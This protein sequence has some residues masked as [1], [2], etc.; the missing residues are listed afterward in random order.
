MEWTGGPRGR[1][2]T[3]ALPLSSGNHPLHGNP[4][5]IRPIEALFEFQDRRAFLEVIALVGGEVVD[6]RREVGALR[7]LRLLRHRGRLRRAWLNIIC[8]FNG[9]MSHLRAVAP[10]DGRR[11]LLR[12]L[13]YFPSVG[14]RG[15]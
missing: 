4:L 5:S 3:T 1:T 13:R 10:C 7:Q 9:F 15:Q 11:H 12:Q 14:D 8:Q 2:G 6:L